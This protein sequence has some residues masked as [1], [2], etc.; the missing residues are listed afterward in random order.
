MFDAKL[1]PLEYTLEKGQSA[2]FRYRV[3]I[4]PRAV[5]PEEL[6]KEADAFAK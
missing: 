5:T 1:P 4:C 6:N 2:T 3:V